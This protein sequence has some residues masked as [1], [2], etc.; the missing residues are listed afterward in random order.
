[1][2]N[3]L[4]EVRGSAFIL[5]H[6]LCTHSQLEKDSG[7]DADCAEEVTDL[8]AKIAIGPVLGGS[9]SRPDTLC[10]AVIGPTSVPWQ[11]FLFLSS[12]QPTCALSCEKGL[13]LIYIRIHLRQIPV[14]SDTYSTCPHFSTNVESR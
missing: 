13:H 5:S 9:E 11:D 4:S 2:I 14:S 12:L 10:S 8:S 7:D 6:T 1:M 3:P